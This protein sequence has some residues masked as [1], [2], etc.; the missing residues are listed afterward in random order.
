MVNSAVFASGT[1]EKTPLVHLLASLHERQLTG[2][3]VFE[4]EN[5]AKSA[6]SITRG[7][8]TKVKL[9]EP[10]ARLG[11]LLVELGLIDEQDR[12]QSYAQAKQQGRLHGQHLLQSKQ[13]DAASLERALHLQ[14]LR[15]LRW[16]CQLSPSTGYG[17]Y[18]SQDFLARWAGEG[19]HVSPLLVIWDLSRTL[20]DL[21]HLAEH[22]KRYEA[23]AITLGA[24]ATLDVFDFSPAERTLTNALGAEPRTLADLRR[25]N[26]V[27]EDCLQRLIFVLSATR[28]IEL[29]PVAGSPTPGEVSP[30][31]PAQRVLSTN[32]A[33]ASPAARV[34]AP[35]DI[36][37]NPEI[38]E[39]RRQL[40]ALAESYEKLDYYE[41]LG[42]ARD[43]PTTQI[44]VAFLGLAKRL[45]PD[46]LGPELAD[47]RPVS[48]KLF[49]RITEARENLSNLESRSRYDA[50]L[51]Q[52]SPGDDR[53][54]QRIQE[55]VNAATWFQKAEVLLKKRM[56]DA[57][58]Q[59]ASRAHQ[60]DPEQADYLALLAWIRAN[61]SDSA[62]E[63]PDL[64]VQLNVA[65]AMSP[66]SEKVR[67]YR[68]QVLTRLGR[69]AE[70]VLDYKFVVSRNPHNI[71]AQREIRLWEMRQQ[72]PST[73]PAQAPATAKLGVFGKLFKR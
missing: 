43:A 14:L 5:G 30:R 18:E 57:A 39:R 53:E 29:Q 59:E 44:H 71:D 60:A 28:Q 23:G 16:I 11:T 37:T 67:F 31:M 17:F 27:S 26:L 56:L 20:A 1:L 41:L 40:L 25:L 47:L 42:V 7:A 50:K 33:G 15:K 3:L 8:P 9:A 19:I 24:R 48:A 45:H 64:L 51:D 61:R 68:A 70:A 73:A 6:V 12:E 21:P 55:I 66:E 72:K 62:A 46:K 13:V 4:T 35:T 65:V 69:N 63:L 10:V 49:A 22:V 54:Q 58:E 52:D 34:A 38:A 32:Q 2:T 36:K